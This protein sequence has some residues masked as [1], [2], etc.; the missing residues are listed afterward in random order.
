M[1]G[2]YQAKLKPND[3]K[4]LTEHRVQESEEWQLKQDESQSRLADIVTKQTKEASDRMSA[5]RNK[6]I[7]EKSQR[8]SADL[9]RGHQSKQ[10]STD[11]QILYID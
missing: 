10:S 6:Q 2:I 5:K 4:E 11:A 9:R 3:F 8:H 7:L 1:E